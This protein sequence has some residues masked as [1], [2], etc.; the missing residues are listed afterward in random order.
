[1][2]FAKS[3]YIFLISFNASCISI[4]ENSDIISEHFIKN[5]IYYQKD[6]VE[7]FIFDKNALYFWPSIEINDNYLITNNYL[8]SKLI[9][10]QYFYINDKN[11]VPENYDKNNNFKFLSD[12][13]KSVTINNQNNQN[14]LIIL[15][16]VYADEVKIN[17][18]VVFSIQDICIEKLGKNNCE[19]E[20]LYC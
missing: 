7:N 17:E 20:I 2:I 1:M 14:N 11:I 9:E 8:C 3:K 15:D 6:L 16:I 13:V 10:T 18:N 5:G 4:N 19:F 12:T